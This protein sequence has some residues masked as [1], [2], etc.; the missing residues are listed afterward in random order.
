VLFGV[1]LSGFAQASRGPDPFEALDRYAEQIV[2]AGIHKRLVE[3][4]QHP[5]SEIYCQS[6]GSTGL[7]E[8]RV[9]GNMSVLFG[10]NVPDHIKDETM[11]KVIA[12]NGFGWWFQ[13]GGRWS[14]TATDAGTGPTGNPC[15]LTYSY[16][17]D[18]VFVPDAG[19]GSGANTLNASMNGAFGGALWKTKIGETFARWDQ[20]MGVTYVE[21]TDDGAAL[22]G[23]VGRNVAPI[24]GD[25]RI[26]MINMTNGGVIAY[27]FF[28]NNGDMVL[29]SD[30]LASFANSS[31]NYRFLRNTVAHEHGHGFGLNHVDPT[32]NTKLMEA[33][34]NTNFDHAQSDDIQG[35]QFLYGD[36][37]ENNDTNGTRS[38]IGTV[39]NGQSV[40]ELSTDKLADVDWYRI[41]VP[42]GKTVTIGCI[43]V[44]STYLQGPQG[45]ATSNRNSLIVHDL[46][47]RAY[48]ADGATL[49]GDANGAPAGSSETLA[50]LVPPMDN[51][52]HILVNGNSG[53]SNDIQRY[54][55]MF[56]LAPLNEAYAPNFISTISGLY[57]SGN[58]ASVAASD[59]NRYVVMEGPPFTPLSPSAAIEFRSTGRAGATVGTITVRVESSTSAAPAANVPQ[60]LDL[61][62]FTSNQWET[63]DTRPST[64]PDSFFDVFIN[65][66]AGRFFEN[67]T[68]N[69]RGRLSFFDPANLFNIGWVVRIDH[70][71]FT[72][73]YQ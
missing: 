63:V 59:D 61:W 66:N 31:S 25:V 38:D 19:L 23:N 72:V 55:L 3:S 7:P 34:L 11:Q 35:G 29:N 32:N 49:L 21:V 33:F 18:G 62:N 26:S 53:T 17:P 47:L 12:K 50:N 36:H 54:N 73:Q 57:Q 71:R 15:T 48:L 70:L 67:G 2:R 22:H 46:R 14:Q 13:V 44:G 68:G 56:N 45:G 9:A 27:N 42:A 69:M 40:V 51:I 39:A 10:A 65:V 60:R 24:R 8:C 6:F 64:A 4:G 58:L 30:F 5:D 20:I 16:V 52:V 1:S 43:P 41:L 37:R 28:P